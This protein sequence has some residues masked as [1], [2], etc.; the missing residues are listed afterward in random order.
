MVVA[1]QKDNW[2]SS[3]MEESDND[4]EIDGEVS[5][6]YRLWFRGGK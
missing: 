3:N 2:E 6:I 1:S 5:E 4:L